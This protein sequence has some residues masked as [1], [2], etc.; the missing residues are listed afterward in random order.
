LPDFEPPPIQAALVFTNPEV[1]VEVDEAPSPT[2][3]L[4]QLKD[5]IR[6]KAKNDPLSIEKVKTIQ[7]A[8][9]LKG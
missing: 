5:F 4:L 2:M 8:I 7:D 6:K 1:E 9:E 3:H